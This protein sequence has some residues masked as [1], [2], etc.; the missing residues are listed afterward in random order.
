MSQINSYGHD[1]T[2]NSPNHAVNQYFVHIIS[3]VTDNNPSWMIQ[4]KKG[5]Q[6]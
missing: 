1:G 3:L 2:V 4:P 6:P 5:E